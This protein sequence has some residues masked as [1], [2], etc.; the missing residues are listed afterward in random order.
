MSRPI[1]SVNAV[2]KRYW[3]GT[4]GA[5]RLRDDLER[6]W[7]RWRKREAAADRKEFWA[8][9]EVSFEV[10]PGEVVGVIGRNGAGKSTLLKILSRITEPTTGEIVLRGR[11]ASLLEVGTGFHPDL[12]GRENIFL[13]GTFLGLSKAE[14][15]ARLDEIIAFAELERFIDTPVKRYSS[16]M[17]VRLAFSVAANLS[18]EILVVDEVLAVGDAEFQKRCI[19]KMS[20]VSQGG[21]RTVLFV[22]HNMNIMRRLCQRVVLLEGG[23]ATWFQ[24]AEEGIEKYLGTNVASP[25]K[26]A[27]GELARSNFTHNIGE[28]ARITEVALAEGQE[29]RQGGPLELC[30]IVRSK[31]AFSTAHVA[32]TFSTLDGTPV[33][34]VD[35]ANSG[36]LIALREG[37]QKVKVRVESNP[38][39]PGAYQCNI[40]IVSGGAVLDH[41]FSAFTW[42]VHPPANDLLSHLGFAGTRPPVRVSLERA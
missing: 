28:T 22:S 4:I 26:V 16:G 9:R 19:G 6:V 12:T 18:P 11:L 41:V 29:M 8:L 7:S 24:N 25:A 1:I 34:T 3:L 2:S 27:T 23:Q 32:C 38:L 13:N 5:T 40:A 10:A 17:Y 20:E 37:E 36:E 15:T 14:V 39:H 21:G 30:F 35:S 33:M 42:D 31:R